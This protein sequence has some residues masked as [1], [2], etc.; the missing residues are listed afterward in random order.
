MSRELTE[1]DGQSEI[2]FQNFTFQQE[3]RAT[4]LKCY[5]KWELHD[6]DKFQTQKY[7]TCRLQSIKID[8][9]AKKI[10]KESISLPLVGNGTSR[11]LWATEIRKNGHEQIQRTIDPSELFN[12]R[13]R[14]KICISHQKR[15][16]LQHKKA[17]SQYIYE[18]SRTQSKC[19][20]EICFFTRPILQI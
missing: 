8:K 7:I 19:W 6:F 12:S 14:G 9:T 1:R 11:L 5:R 15:Y 2:H 13:N 20:K 17:Q 3:Q 18:S 4:C 10:R 16:I